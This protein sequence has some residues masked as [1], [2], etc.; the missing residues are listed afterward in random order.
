MLKST[1]GMS[2]WGQRAL[3]FVMTHFLGS[4]T[5]ME[6]WRCLARH[7]T[8]HLQ[9]SGRMCTEDLSTVSICVVAPAVTLLAADT[10]PLCLYIPLSWPAW[11][12]LAHLCMPAH[13][14]LHVSGQVP[15][16]R[17]S[18]LCCQLHPAAKLPSC[19]LFIVK[20]QKHNDQTTVSEQS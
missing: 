15:A 17:G 11:V 10:N 1:M 8:A 9:A 14:Y 2:P 18:E 4:K 3:H 6:Q 7:S 12:R 19:K 16:S 5:A 20:S 13:L